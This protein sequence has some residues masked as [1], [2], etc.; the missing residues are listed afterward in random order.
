MSKEIDK[1]CEDLRERLS[2]VENRLHTAQKNLKAIPGK[3]EEALHK[4]LADLRDSFQTEKSR[5]VH[6][7]NELLA[8]VENFVE[9]TKESIAQWKESRDQGKLEH[10]AKRSEKHAIDA[11]EHAINMIGD[12]EEAIL[13]AA[14]AR[15]DLT[16]GVPQVETVAT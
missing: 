11:I 6:I 1:F 13:Q 8:K 12:A 10:R 2:A 15:A 16:S 4:S 5:I 7:Q 14:I 3:T 9:E